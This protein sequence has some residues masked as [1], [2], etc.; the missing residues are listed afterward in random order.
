MLPRNWRWVLPMGNRRTL[1]I[2]R[3]I[4]SF[5]RLIKRCCKKV[6]SRTKKKFAT[7]RSRQNFFP[8]VK[9][10]V[11]TNKRSW[12][13]E[14]I[15][16]VT[17][18]KLFSPKL[19]SWDKRISPLNFLDN[20]LTLNTSCLY[21]SLLF[22]KCSP[23]WLLFGGRNTHGGGLSDREVSSNPTLACWAPESLR[24]HRGACV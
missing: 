11:S 20:H 7:S 18:V 12:R 21:S 2:G 24:P 5:G 8:N 16:W 6:T 3:P 14:V 15:M 17:Q 10:C 22:S 9:S 23:E 13:T 4:W 1:V 19:F